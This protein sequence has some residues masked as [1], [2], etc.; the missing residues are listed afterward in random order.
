MC[1]DVPPMLSSEKKQHSAFDKAQQSQ[2][3]II[4]AALSLGDYT[5][6]AWTTTTTGPQF[7]PQQGLYKAWLQQETASQ[8][9]D[10]SGD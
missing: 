9:E 5:E 4:S 8:S 7:P 10:H 6:P 2:Q 1:H 3:P